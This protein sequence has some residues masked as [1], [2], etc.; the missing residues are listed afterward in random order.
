MNAFKRII[1]F[2]PLI[3]LIIGASSEMGTEPTSI[4]G[5]N[6]SAFVPVEIDKTTRMLTTIEYEHYEIHDGDLY[7]TGSYTTIDDGN[8]RMYL[9][10]TD[11]T[12]NW[13][14]MVWEIDGTAVTTIEFYEGTARAGGTPMAIGNRNRNTADHHTTLITHTPGA[15][16]DGTLIYSEKFGLAAGNQ[17]R[18]V[19]ESRQ[20]V[21]WILARNTKYLLKITSGTDGN[22]ISSRFRWYELTDKN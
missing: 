20:D 5:W 8:T 6:E 18:Q 11:D 9:L 19:G 13:A 16:A 14:H 17:A 21:E 12:T 22:V 15:G 2:I 3:F 4:M 10:T 7:Q 1:F